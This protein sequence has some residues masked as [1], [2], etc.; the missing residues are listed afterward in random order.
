MAAA[1]FPSLRSSMLNS[2]E[3]QNASSLVA[4][5]RHLAVDNIEVETTCSD[6]ELARMSENIAREWRKFGETQAHWSVLTSNEFKPESIDQN[7]DRFYEL[8]NDDIIH[9]IAA[10]KR[11]A[12]WQDNAK[13]L[14]FGCGVG[15]LSLALAPHVAHVTGIDISAPH[16]FHARQRAEQT[17]VDNVAFAPIVSIAG[18]DDLPNFDLIISLIVLQHNPPPVIVVLL[19]KLLNRLSAG[20]VAVIQ[21]PTY[22]VGQRFFVADYLANK[23]PSMEMNAVPQRVIYEVIDQMG[24]KVIEVREDGWIGATLGLSH[25]FVIQRP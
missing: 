19:Q 12:L 25:T 18:I 3:F 11:N 17:G 10:L 4:V 7:L 23:Q 1:D 6:A 21:I 22:I 5:G 15:R 24:C 16:L 8:G 14:D 13:A 20:G 2:H 9:V